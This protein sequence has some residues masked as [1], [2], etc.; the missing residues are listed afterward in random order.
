MNEQDIIDR[1]LEN[2]P[3]AVIDISGEDCSFELYIISELFA[4]QR[5]LKRQQDLLALFKDELTSGKLHAL[6]LILKTPEEHAGSLNT[7]LVQLK[8]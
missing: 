2:Y 5:S 6:S 4:E 7:G 3:Q 8:L 1:I